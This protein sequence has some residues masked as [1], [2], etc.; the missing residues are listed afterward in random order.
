MFNKASELC[1][2]VS[3]C[4]LKEETGQILLTGNQNLLG[5]VNLRNI[6]DNLYRFPCE[7]VLNEEWMK[8]AV[9]LSMSLVA[10]VINVTLLKLIKTWLPFHAQKYVYHVVFLV[11]V[12]KEA[13]LSFRVG[14]FKV[15]WCKHKYICFEILMWLI[16]RSGWW[17]KIFAK[18]SNPDNL[19]VKKSGK[20][21]H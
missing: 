2:V 17:V 7:K 11:K 5:S 19:L 14:P 9:N 6:A 18:H 1:D 10:N 15:F 4:I 8:T 20:L 21:F 3:V 13:K 16:F 12:Q